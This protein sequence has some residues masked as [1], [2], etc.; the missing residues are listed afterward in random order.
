MG[1]AIGPHQDIT[2][3]VWS[4]VDGEAR[5]KEHPGTFEIPPRKEREQLQPGYFAKLIFVTPQ[6]VAQNVGE[7]MWVR[8]LERK[9]GAS[10][11]YYRG[12][13]DNSPGL[14][15]GI[16]AGDELQFEPKNVIDIEQLRGGG[17]GGGALILLAFAFLSGKKRGRR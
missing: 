7:R 11:V 12:Q 3:Y 6:M 1:D 15:S 8:V 9:T 14:V 13:L 4:L 10:G 16:K 5:A 17:G 2:T